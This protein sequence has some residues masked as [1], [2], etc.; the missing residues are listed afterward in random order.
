MK[1][2][3]LL[4]EITFCIMRVVKNKGIIIKIFEIWQ[5]R[6]YGF[7]KNFLHFISHPGK[8]AVLMEEYLPLLLAEKY[9][10]D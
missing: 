7:G 1:I 9:F 3:H 2:A 6:F 5:C 8:I 4:A 10:F